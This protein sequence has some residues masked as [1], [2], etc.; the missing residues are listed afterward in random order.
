MNREDFK[1]LVNSYGTDIIRWPLQLRSL[2]A[3]MF[4]EYPSL[5]EE[6][7][8]IDALLDKYQVD[9]ANDELLETI[10][11]AAYDNDN[12]PLML[13]SFWMK[14]GMMAMCA[15]FG[16]YCGSFSLQTDTKTMATV[17]SMKPMLLGPTK[18][19][20]VML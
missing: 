4:S 13:R 14:A 6:A 10:L 5:V 2:G 16:F 12:R 1:I 15:V 9:D 18:L 7:A 20:E 3:P 17:S 19:S 8:G 11:R